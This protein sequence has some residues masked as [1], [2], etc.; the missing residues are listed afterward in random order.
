MST[1]IRV[2]HHYEDLEEYKD[3][4]WRN[5]KGAERKK[6]IKASERLMKNIPKFK[7]NM[8]KA[9]KRWRKSCEHNLTVI[10]ANRIAWLG[11]AG[12]CIGVGSPEECTRAAW[13]LLNDEERNNAN[14][15]ALE[16]LMKWDFL[17]PGV[18]RDIF[19]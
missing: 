3:G 17:Y 13:Y 4:M 16:V 7:G 1:P 6:Y 12:C 9:I 18:Q 15:A 5:V 19:K 14:R 8:S 10:A 2:F 11:H